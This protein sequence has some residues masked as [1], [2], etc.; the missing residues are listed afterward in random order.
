[1]WIHYDAGA[2]DDV[3]FPHKLSHIDKCSDWFD[4][5]NKQIVE[6]TEDEM[7]M[8]IFSEKL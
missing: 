6:I 1:V 7:N 4:V 5:M 3:K 8:E 2:K